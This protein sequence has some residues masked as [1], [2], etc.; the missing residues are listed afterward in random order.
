[1]TAASSSSGGGAI[2]TF[3]LAMLVLYIAAY[4]RLFT[5][6]SGVSEGVAGHRMRCPTA[7]VG[8]DRP[9]LQSLSVLQDRGPTRVV[10]DSLLHPIRRHRDRAHYRHGRCEDVLE[11]IRVRNG[12]VVAE[13]HFY[14]DPGF[15]LGGLYEADGS[16]AGIDFLSCRI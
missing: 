5:K 2:L 7:R 13:L 15:W 4:W 14:P 6:V 9:H 8:R 16:F 12:L 10:A 1:M 11:I 3:F